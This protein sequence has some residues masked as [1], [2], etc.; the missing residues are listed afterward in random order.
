MI[1]KKDVTKYGLYM[2]LF[3]AVGCLLFVTAILW[4]IGKLGG[5]FFMIAFV[6]FVLTLMK[7]SA[8]ETELYKK[9][10]KQFAGV[11]QSG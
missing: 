6:I 10:E 7:A 4:I 5:I 2:V 3:G 9:V 11:T 8:I 1:T